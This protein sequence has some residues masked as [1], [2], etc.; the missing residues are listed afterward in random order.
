MRVGTGEAWPWVWTRVVVVAT[1][2]ARDRT[3]VLDRH[4]RPESPE[5]LDPGGPRLACPR[6][7]SVTARSFGGAHWLAASPLG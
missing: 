5:A 4:L 2:L 1:W 7:P 6:L 3:L